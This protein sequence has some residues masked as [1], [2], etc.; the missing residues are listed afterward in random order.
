MVI[1]PV[2][3]HL[4]LRLVKLF[5]QHLELCLV[6][7]DRAEGNHTRLSDVGNG[8]VFG[9]LA[10]DGNGKALNELLHAV[11]GVADDVVDLVKKRDSRLKASHVHAIVAVFN[12]RDAPKHIRFG[13]DERCCRCHEV[14]VLLG[15]HQLARL[16]TSKMKH[17]LLREHIEVGLA[18]INDKVHAHHRLVAWF[19]GVDHKSGTRVKRVCLKRHIGIFARLNVGH[20]LTNGVKPIGGL[21]VSVILPGPVQILVQLFQLALNPVLSRRIGYGLLE[22]KAVL[23][24]DK[25]LRMVFL[26]DVQNVLADFFRPVEDG[27]NATA[28]PVQKLLLEHILNVVHHCGVQFLHDILGVDV[29]KRGVNVQTP[30]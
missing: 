21:V 12:N 8:S 26:D 5:R 14:V 18:V 17:I 16:R 10:V 4:G 9:E 29:L 24:R 30:E 7:T 13:A 2:H 6:L 3:K 20:A 28:I 25:L 1:N 22:E 27:L 15:G 19:E 11:T 23:K